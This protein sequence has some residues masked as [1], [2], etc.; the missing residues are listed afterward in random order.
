[1]NASIIRRYGDTDFIT[2]LRAIAATMVVAFHCS[3]FRE[4]GQIGENVTEAGRYGV[5]VFFVISG[6]TIAATY[7]GAP[8]YL[9]YLVRRL[10]RIAPVYFFVIGAAIALTVAGV[11]TGTGWSARFGVETDAYN[12][13]MHLTFMSFWDYKIANSLIGV[14]W[15]IPVEVFWYVILPWVIARAVGVRKAVIF[16]VGLAALAFATILIGAQ[17]GPSLISEWFPT[18]YGP[19]F[20]L[21]V[22]TYKLRSSTQMIGRETMAFWGG[23]AIFLFACVAAPVMTGAWVGVATALIIVGHRSSGGVSILTTTPLL[24][25]GSISYSIYLWHALVVRYFALPESFPGYLE[26]LVVFGV[27]LVLSVPTY[28]LVEKPTNRWG[29][30]IAKS[31]AVLKRQAA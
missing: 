31:P 4:F 15:T 18:T 6:F 19:Y 10:M 7:L 2:G 13:L 29:A 27:T 28:L 1:M 11:I 26:F 16:M 22:L 20:L 17:L 12:L 14:E 5:Q 25:A 3:I 21:G 23:V 24:F 9:S 30:V 8:S